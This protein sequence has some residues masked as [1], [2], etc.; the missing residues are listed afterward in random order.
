MNYQLIKRSLIGLALGAAACCLP[1]TPV[2]SY[3]E[4]NSQAQNAITTPNTSREIKTISALYQAWQY[5]VIDTMLDVALVALEKD[6]N[7]LVSECTGILNRHPHMFPATRSKLENA[8]RFA[9]YQNGT[10]ID[11]YA[12]QRKLRTAAKRCDHRLQQLSSYIVN[13]IRRSGPVS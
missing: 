8:I 9:Q 1:S 6:N 10:T 11:E 3:P 12:Y 2:Q 4:Q 13:L 7:K 5:A